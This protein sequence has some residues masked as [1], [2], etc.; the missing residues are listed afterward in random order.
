MRGT[1]VMRRGRLVRRERAGPHPMEGRR[2][3]VGA[4]V[5]GDDLGAQLEH[6]D[7]ADGRRTDSKSVYRRWTRDA[8]SIEKGNDR[9]RPSRAKPQD[10]VPD[11]ARAL[12]MCKSGY[13]PSLRGQGSEGWHD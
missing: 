7:Y 12:Q 13:K 4:N 6:M 8:G 1:Y 2:L 3:G 9:Q 10:I 11:V 5:I